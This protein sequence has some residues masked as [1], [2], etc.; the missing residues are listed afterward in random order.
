MAIII[1][2]VDEDERLINRAVVPSHAVTPDLEE[3]CDVYEGA[4]EYFDKWDI[5]ARDAQFEI[6]SIVEPFYS[7]DL[8]VEK[9]S[10]N[11]VCRIVTVHAD[12]E[13]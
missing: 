3:L 5:Q 4:I 11:D 1:C 10:L 7:H 9:L 8:S 6:R 13:V 12:T 2:F